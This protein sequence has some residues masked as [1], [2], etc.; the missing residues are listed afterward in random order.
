MLAS[1]LAISVALQAAASPGNMWDTILPALTDA[2]LAVDRI[3]HCTT[4]LPARRGL[5]AEYQAL[6]GRAVAVSHAV[7]DLNPSIDPAMEVAVREVAA[8]APSCTA[9]ALR[10]YSATA[11]RALAMVE[12]S[13]RAGVA[14]QGR[15]LW[16]GNLHLCAGRVVA[17]EP[18]APDYRGG[19]PGLVLR[20]A[21]GFAPEVRALTARRVRRTIA[22]VLDG[23]VIIA[24]MVNE[25]VSVA[26]EI[27]SPDPLPA[28]R[29]RAAIAEPC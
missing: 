15:G 13:L 14:Q 8:G 16:F 24:P 12:A 20:F 28:D 6:L 3:G 22:V 27:R 23:T 4:E 25:P 10:S 17:V 2:Q 7:Q 19:Q 5:E 1:A 11:R 9:T 29:I 26:V 21:A 18:V